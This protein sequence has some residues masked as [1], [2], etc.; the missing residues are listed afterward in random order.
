VVIKFTG[1]VPDEELIKYYQK[2]KVYQ[3][4]EYEGLPNALCEAMLCECL[5]EQG[6]A[7]FQQQ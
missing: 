5:L 4:S 3:L 1:L 7:V 6:I 2:A